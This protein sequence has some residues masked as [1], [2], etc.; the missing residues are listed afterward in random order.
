MDVKDATK[1]AVDFF[2]ELP[3]DHYLKGPLTVEEVE[4]IWADEEGEFI[5]YITLGYYTDIQDIFNTGTGTLPM[6]NYKIFGINAKTGEITSMKIRE[7][8]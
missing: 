8:R 5:W 1:L 4:K 3:G 7:F 6:K 2:K